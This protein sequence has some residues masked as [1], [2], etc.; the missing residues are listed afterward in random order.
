MNAHPHPIVSRMYWLLSGEPYTVAEF[1][2]AWLAISVKCA[3]KGIPEGLARGCGGALRADIPCPKQR[4]AAALNIPI[5]NDRRDCVR[6]TS[7]DSGRSQPCCGH[8]AAT[9]P[10]DSIG[11]QIKY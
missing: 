1:R 2:P 7:F 10:P 5:R 8:S 3:S 9:R 6:E 4:T 11:K